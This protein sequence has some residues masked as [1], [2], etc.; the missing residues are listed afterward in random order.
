[1]DAGHEVVTGP[2]RAARTGSALR[3]SGTMAR[4]RAARSRAGM[5][6]VIAWS[7][8]SSSVAKCPSLTC[9]RRQAASSVTTFTSRAVVEVGHRRVVEGQVP[10]LADAQAAEVERE[11]GAAGRRSARTRPRAGPA[12]R[13]S[14]RPGVRWAPRSARGSSA[15]SWPDGRGRS[16]RTRPCGRRRRRP[17]A[18][19]GWLPPGVDEGDLGVAGGEHGVG[20]ALFGHRGAQEPGRP[21]GGGPGHGRRGVEGTHVG[22]PALTRRS[23]TG[24]SVTRGSVTHGSTVGD[25]R[26]AR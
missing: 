17:R 2:S 19:R 20:H 26:N 4:T 15:G 25:A 9:W 5:V 8:T 12:R 3:A 6:T 21:V 7:G 24:G 1:M 14:G 22:A 13:C 16:R 23:V 11:C 10:V 18:R